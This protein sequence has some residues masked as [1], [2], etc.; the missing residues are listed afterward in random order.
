[1]SFLDDEDFDAAAAAKAFLSGGTAAA[2]VAAPQ[3]TSRGRYDDL[4]EKHADAN[5]LDPDLLRAVT[6]QES[7]FNPRAISNKGAQGLMQLMP[8]TAR[9]FGVK[10]VYDPDQNIAGGAKYLK[11]LLDK[12]NGSVPLA[13]AGYN[14]G[15]GAVV[16]YGGIPP[17][18]QTRD[19]VKKITSRY[20][21]AGYAAAF[22]PDAAAK[23]FLANDTSEASD[24]FDPDAAAKDFLGSSTPTTNPT[25]QPYTPVASAPPVVPDNLSVQSTDSDIDKLTQISEAAKQGQLATAA[26]D[27]PVDLTPQRPKLQP[28][29]AQPTAQVGATPKKKFATSE[30]VVTDLPDETDVNSLPTPAPPA[31]PVIGTMD[32]DPSVDPEERTRIAANRF[33]VGRETPTGPVTPQDIDNWIAAQKAAGRPVWEGDPKQRTFAVYQD[34]LDDIFNAKRKSLEQLNEEQKQRVIAPPTDEQYRQQAL[35]QLRAEK[36][37]ANFTAMTRRGET[38]DLEPTED[39]INQRIDELRAAELPLEE[40]EKAY[41]S[42]N[43]PLN[44]SFTQGVIGGA[45]DIITQ[46]GGALRPALG[47][48]NPV[49]RFGRGMAAVPEYANQGAGPKDLTENVGQFIG[50]LLP[51]LGEL[52]VL[53]GGPV[54]KFALMGALRASGQ[55]KSA[56][57]IMAATGKEAAIG[58]VFRGAQE[59]KAPL[60][61]LGTVF[62]GSAIV[63]AATGVP[64]DQNLHSSI[65]NTLFEAQGIYG[66]K[67]SGKFYRFWKG[68]EPLTV[69]VTPKGE[70]IVPK[71]NVEPTGGEIV[72][73]PE[74]QIYK[75]VTPEQLNV[76]NS[77]Q[78]EVAE[79]TDTTPT[80]ENEYAGNWFHGTS[81]DLSKE[82]IK[83]NVPETG[84]RP[85]ISLSRSAL[86]AEEYGPGET[87][88]IPIGNRFPPKSGEPGGVYGY[89]LHPTNPLTIDAKGKLWAEMPIRTIT[90]EAAANG[91]DLVILKNIKDGKYNKSFESDT[92]IVL[93]RSVIKEANFDQQTNPEKGFDI[94]DQTGPKGVGVAAV[95]EQRDTERRKANTNPVTGLGSKVAWEGAKGRIEADPNQELISLDVN[96]M[97]LA[98]DTTSH[99]HVDAT[100]LSK[101]GSAIKTVLDRN[102]IDTRN[103]FTPGGDEA[104]VAVPKG[105]GQRIRDEIEKEFG[106]V[107]ITAERDYVNDRTGEKINKGDIIPVTLSGSHGND[108][109]SAEVDLQT[110]K[111]QS[112]QDNPIRPSTDADIQKANEEFFA[113]NVGRAADNIEEGDFVTDL[114]GHHFTVDKVED[115]M[116]TIRDAFSIGKYEADSNTV[117]L[118]NLRLWQKVHEPEQTA[119]SDEVG[120]FENPKEE[121]PS[122]GNLDMRGLESEAAKPKSGE[123][124]F[125]S[126]ELAGAP[127][128]IA[129]RIHDA[130]T[131]DPIP[132]ITREGS[133]PEARAHASAKAATPRIT[134]DLLARVFP[135]SYREPERMAK[136]ADILNKDNILAGYDK[137][138]ENARRA[139]AIGDKAAENEWLEQ[140]A[141]IATAHDLPQIEKDVLQAKSDPEISG[142]IERYKQ[143]VNTYL[144]ALYN[145]VRNTG[146]NSG[147]GDEHAE[148]V[149]RG[150]IFGA[151]VNLLP[152]FREEEMLDIGD[153][154]KPMPEVGASSFRNP[155]VA[156]D[157]YQR[158]AKF[159]GDYSTNM[160]AILN[161]VI[162]PRLN[163][164][165]KVDFYNSLLNKGSAIPADTGKMAPEGYANFTFEMPETVN[166][167]T[168]Q[169]KKR[170]W[171]KKELVEE[172]R[173]VLGTDIKLKQSGLTKALNTLQIKQLVDAAAH[174]KN[175]HSV[176]A[177]ANASGKAMLDTARR[178]PFI[179]TADSI[180]R[181]SSVV[182]EI[183]ADSPEIR[184]EMAEM[185]KLGLLRPEYELSK[186][187]KYTGFN[188]LI[189]TV[190]AA[191]RITMNRFF[192]RLV[193]NDVAKNTPENRA[194][195]VQ[196]IG[197]YNDRLMGPKMRAMKQMGLAPFIVAGRNFNRQGIRRI[198]GNPGFEALSKRQAAKIRSLNVVSGLVAV[199]VAPALLNYTT[200]GNVFG[201]PGTP[202]GAWDTGMNDEKGKHKV[203]DIATALGHRRGMRMLGIDALLQGLKEG[204]S[205]SEIGDEAVTDFTTTIA[206][207]WIGPALN[208][209]FMAATGSKLD[210]RGGPIAEEAR[211]MDGEGS[212][213]LE[214]LR[215]ALKNQ[216]PAL[217]SLLSPAIGTGDEKV[218][219]IVKRLAE[220]F[221]KGPEQAMG[222]RILSS[223]AEQLLA[224]IQHQQGTYTRSPE[225]KKRHAEV[226]QLV[227]GIK[228]DNRAGQEAVTKALEE[229]RITSAD[230]KT[231]DSMVKSD[232][233]T[234]GVNDL[235]LE[236]AK[237]VFDRSTPEQQA[238]LQPIMLAKEAKQMQDE[239]TLQKNIRVRQAESQLLQGNT[240]PLKDLGK[241]DQTKIIKDSQLT[242]DQQTFSG[243]STIEKLYIFKN[244]NPVDQAQ[245]EPF[246]RKL[247]MTL[248]RKKGKTSDDV[249]Q[250]RDVNEALR[251]YNERVN[252][253]PQE[254]QTAIRKASQATLRLLLSR[255][256]RLSPQPS[257]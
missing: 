200:T 65:V 104:Y 38:P 234:A 13:L 244:S 201:R 232:Y 169:V 90:D 114:S 159:T 163:E 15:E 192:D 226:L 87:E 45:G 233:L 112:K 41:T 76:V 253:L 127:Y 219:S 185:A 183:Q 225:S 16:K 184:K 107:D 187:E 57:D 98:N 33:L 5:G 146:E 46:I 105:H 125:L 111:E 100:V 88:D 66:D 17:Y 2:P 31:R 24:N 23:D 89:T 175:L 194:N 118:E 47:S 136:T 240:A 44:P 6:T 82:G 99:G 193:E 39:E 62:G 27:V 53:P 68:G 246:M 43:N 103:A 210:L 224:K 64:I 108:I 56:G 212:Q 116:A 117:P 21:G 124:G 188:Y 14:A 128:T 213:K 165:T 61:K 229:G 51:Q 29:V 218:D 73:D 190:D 9:R 7:T 177:G 18:A 49:S 230:L 77:V 247:Q 176:I 83:M 81:A 63:N 221:L 19:Y 67:I 74:N 248:T 120:I 110:R 130:I 30:P 228:D 93:D 144:E 209:G 37:E 154:S 26:A 164:A 181:I 95:A 139:T 58:G 75:S 205:P 170:I 3:P 50:E 122:L 35:D 134:A 59:F 249:Q 195:F 239:A 245:Q 42:A 160:E 92:A 48:Q 178:V 251:S 102:N 216:N 149:G 133:G 25:N 54:G 140:A 60:A 223:P 12:F 173:G 211:N 204:Q 78:K 167:E 168:R 72:L 143:H 141:D 113:K 196:Q 162:A 236:D 191:S 174:V 202:L 126:T 69:G 237:R 214:N 250:L 80:S 222:L 79:K 199:A 32:F 1:M 161:A 138:I 123:E 242:D 96:R 157:R 150:R 148:P 241:A 158:S 85:V 86:T 171:L 227:A 197:E 119:H 142:N 255:R 22:D 254:Q 52:T 256:P 243:K 97:K 152:K 11:F 257:N 207:P 153:L 129:K 215:V 208:F 206:H 137:A 70:V 166:G 151:R 179:S 135:D 198:T 28:K 220:G 84:G 145:K 203:V 217:Y 34:M 182:R 156:R 235:S 10:D 55:G 180:A 147:F 109:A 155:N 231:I 115:G 132:S 131:I 36:K 20:K 91:H 71:G 40:K 101:L 94:V 106:S 121:V 252:A 8:G 186:I 238:K 189:H 172:V 4:F